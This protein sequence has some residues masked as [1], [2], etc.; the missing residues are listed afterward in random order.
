MKSFRF[1]L[2]LVTALL[3]GNKGI[4]QTEINDDYYKPAKSRPVYS[5]SS[6]LIYAGIGEGGY[7]PYSGLRYTQ[8]PN[9][10]LIYERVIFKH[11][12]P[13]T[14]NAG[15]LLSFKNIASQYLDYNTGFKYEQRWNYYHIGARLA[16][17][18]HI[19]PG[20]SIVPYAGAMIGYYITDFKFSSNDPNYS[21]PTDPAYYL[22]TNRYPDF[23]A[24]SILAGIRSTMGY[25]TSVWLELAYGYSSVSFGVCY[26]L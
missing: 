4:A 22:T 11:L 25:H 10:T 15:P 5:E 13:G 6:N 21:D 8:K 9:I 12:G 2:V 24:M 20:N 19:F 14:L 26:S 18:L 17:N 1:F 23:F 3:S 16:Y 7:Y